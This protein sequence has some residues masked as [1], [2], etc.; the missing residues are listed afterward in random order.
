MSN[1]IINGDRI[2]LYTD[3]TAY[4]MQ[5]LYGRF[6]VHLYYGAR[7]G[8]T[9][10]RYEKRY[11]SFSPYFHDYGMEFSPDCALL[12]YSFF[13]G[14]DFRTTPL[15]LR[16]AD[17]DAV[18]RFDYV[19]CRTYAGR[20]DL[21]VLPSADADG[22][23][24]TLELTLC[25][26]LT[27]CTL[28]LNYTVFPREDVISRG[29]KLTNGGKA[30]VTVEKLMCLMLDL[31]DCGYELISLYGQHNG[32]RQ[33]QRTPLI[34]GNQRVMSR[35]GA[36][37]HQFNPFIALARP[38]ATERAGQVY[39]FNLVYS[40]DFL[41]EVEVDQFGSARVQ[42]GLGSENFR[43]RLEP[44]ES[45]TSP[46][47]VMTFSAE[48]CGKMSRNFHDFI[49]ARIL[50]PEPFEKRPVVLNTWEACLF[51]IDETEVERFAVAAADAGMDMLVMD[52]GWFGKRNNDRAGLGDWYVNRD[53]FKDGLKPFVD[54][55]K[56]HG[57]KFGIWIEPEMVNPDS[58][59]FRAHP[60]WALGTDGRENTR[61]RHQLVLDM[62]NPDVI[63]YLKKSFSD[64][65]DGVSIDYFKWDMNR[66]MSEVSSRTLP[67]ERKDE[68][69]YRYMLGVYG[70]YRWFREHFPHAMIE[71]CSGGGGRYD[72][73]MMKFSTMIWTSDNT[74]PQDR[75][76]IQYG[77]MLAYP[78][79]TMSC[80]VSNPR[81]DMD[82][83]RFRYHVALNGALGYELH[84]P[85][86]SDEL[87]AIVKKQVEDYRIYEPLI[88]R[89]DYFRLLDPFEDNS[90]AYYFANKERTEF[91]LTFAQNYP[92]FSREHTLA[93]PEAEQDAEYLDTVSGE[94]YTGAALRSGLT[95]RTRNKDFNS[96]LWH[97][98]KK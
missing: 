45:F 65:F 44:G 21:G 69:A 24:E 58:D 9:V 92:E 51:D 70:L 17:G 7:G 53:K 20:P 83:L 59:L 73:G 55:I 14:G 54:K 31:P 29:I 60:E 90:T 25:D 33:V 5:I 3:N 35:R 36:S 49:R 98:V 2:T 1:I 66:H 10:P 27:G 30:P 77:S 16:N 81:G 84:L 97:F 4:A 23:T 52:D 43:W 64:S 95:V 28:L 62:A 82:S 41:D 8:E 91:L 37:S 6:P 11:K 76:R 19:S 78:A 74:R 13:G 96:T 68:T 47:A 87:K 46:E 61:S 40:G 85:D 71:N 88:L 18:T 86:S 15:K 80:H 50:P 39:G 42:L 67:P 12:E 75:I 22:D 48:G 89:G 72:L 94:T 56:S 63:E 32:E 38:G 57:I 26:S 79:A 34:H 93:I